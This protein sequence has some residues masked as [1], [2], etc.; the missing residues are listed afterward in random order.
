M[1]D[2]T[3]NYPRFK[4]RYYADTQFPGPRAGDL[5]PEVVLKDS[6]GHDVDIRSF[7]GKWLVIETGSITC[8]QYVANISTMNALQETYPDTSFVVIYVREAH[9]GNRIKAHSD[10][11]DKGKRAISAGEYGEKRKVL[12]DDLD[13][14]FHRSVGSR[15]N[16]IY[17]LN[18][19]QR[20]VF[21]S[22]WNV[23]EKI[24]E[25]LAAA[26]ETTLY[27]KEHFEPK[28]APLPLAWKVISRA[29]G[30]AL[31]DL[32]VGLPSLIWQHIGRATNNR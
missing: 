30:I 31:F 5:F 6:Q 26:D 7:Q 17:I 24:D 4:A 19:S 27:T 3:Y 8:P 28:L 14:S 12:I 1:G 21:R 22:D 16:Q 18:P 25:I 13:G 2:D 15:P 10:L 23:P 20:V 9:P 11:D 32:F 29:G